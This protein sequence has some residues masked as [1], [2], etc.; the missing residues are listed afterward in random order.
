V[1]GIRH[2]ISSGNDAFVRHLVAFYQGRWYL[3]R[4]YSGRVGIRDCKFRVVGR[5]RARRHVH[6]RDSAF[7]LPAL[8]DGDQSLY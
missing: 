3:G 8:A 2:R 7:A 1:D 5:N 4:Q 6:F